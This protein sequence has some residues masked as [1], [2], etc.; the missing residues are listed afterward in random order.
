MKIKCEKQQIKLCKMY[1]VQKLNDHMAEA[2]VMYAQHNTTQHKCQ[3]ELNNAIIV[4]KV[5][6]VVE[7]GESGEMTRPT[8]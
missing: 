8:D 1:S 2:G 4:M 3:S 6:V 5:N 7:N